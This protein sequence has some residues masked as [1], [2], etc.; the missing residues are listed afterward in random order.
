MEV[1]DLIMVFGGFL[2]TLMIGVIGYFL[3]RTMNEL[4]EALEEVRKVKDTAVEAKSKI[5]LIE[6]EYTL[7]HSHLTEKFDELC[8]T[9][10]D[11][12][13]ELKALNIELLKKKSD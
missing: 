7:K 13:K 2:G 12:T 6:R 1:G 10:K 3:R 11:L 5:E 8:D 4:D 9:V